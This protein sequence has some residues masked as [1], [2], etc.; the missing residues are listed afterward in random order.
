MSIETEI[1]ELRQA[2]E[3]LTLAVRALHGCEPVQT[4]RAVM[5]AIPP[6]STEI[7]ALR[8]PS[9]AATNDAPPSKTAP[10]GAIRNEQLIELARTLM[11]RNG[12]PALQH[13]LTDQL[14][15]G[16]VNQLKA[17]WQRQDFVRLVSEVL[18]RAT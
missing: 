17:P 18:E 10:T 5:E 1:R 9:P 8:E 4:M 12:K 14:G 11:Q 16:A 2:I 3:T 7:A 13:I 15:V 6:V